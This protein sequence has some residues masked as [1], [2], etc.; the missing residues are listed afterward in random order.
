M[1]SLRPRGRTPAPGG[2][3]AR[4]SHLAPPLPTMLTFDTFFKLH[5]DGI[6]L[7]TLLYWTFQHYGIHIVCSSSLFIFFAQRWLITSWMEERTARM[8]V[9]FPSGWASKDSSISS[10]PQSH[11]GWTEPPLSIAGRFMARTVSSWE[12]SDH[13][14]SASVKNVSTPFTVNPANTCWA[15]PMCKSLCRCCRVNN[16]SHEAH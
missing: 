5:V 3:R 16:P 13:S 2:S 8:S 9:R 11:M 10:S 4:R 6:I 1:T 14:T 15:P 7:Y 12:L